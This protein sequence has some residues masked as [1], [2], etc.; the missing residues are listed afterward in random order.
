MEWEDGTVLLWLN[1]IKKEKIEQNIF[2]NFEKITENFIS[3]F[4]FPHRDHRLSM[5]RPAGEDSISEIG[6]GKGRIFQLEL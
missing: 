4:L 3:Q 5:K 1:L 2:A 6:K